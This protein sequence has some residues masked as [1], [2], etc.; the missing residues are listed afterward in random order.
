MACSWG[1]FAAAAPEM[2]AGGRRLLYQWGLGL[3]FLATVRPDGGP[4]LHRMCP[5]IHDDGLYAF[6]TD[7]P[8]RRDLLRDGRYALHTEGPPDNDDEFY[9]TGRAVVVPPDDARQ[10]PIYKQFMEERKLE[11]A[12][13]A[14][15]DD[16]LFELLLERVL[17]GVTTGHG[18]P[19][20]FTFWR[21]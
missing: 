3:G 1:E 9:V 21:G 17:Y 7:S 6:I 5:I 16:I 19:P 4:R 12:P 13:G 2:A 15:S 14:I 8:K 20:E 11:V 18:A 10:E